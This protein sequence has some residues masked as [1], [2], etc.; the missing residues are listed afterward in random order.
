VTSTA[1]T[2]TAATSTAVTASLA[3][4][5][6][7]PVPAAAPQEVVHQA[8]RC[9]IDWLGVALAGSREP[10]T[11]IVR[12]TAEAMSPGA[13]AWVVGSRRRVGAP[14]AALVNGFAAH[15]LDYDDTFN[16]GRTTVHG[17]APVWPAVMAAASLR[18]LGGADAIAAF[19]AGFET[20]VRV[21]LAAGAGHYDAGWHVTGTVGHLGAAAAASRVLGLGTEQVV[22]AL[23]TAATQAAGMKAVYGSMGKALHPGK[24]AMDGLL[25]AALC[26][27]GFTSSDTAIEGHRGFLHLFAPDPE[28]ARALEG[29]GERWTVL[30]DGFKAYACGSLT[31]PS[32]DAV[33]ALRRAHGITPDRIA[34]IDLDV[35]DY[36]ITTTGL[37]EPRTGLEGKFSIFHCAAVAAVDGAARLAQFT[38]ERVNDGEVTAVRGRV[39]A[40][41]DPA[42]AKD[43]ATVT[44]T[45]T[46]G[47]AF[48]HTTA[49]NRGTPG[50]PVPDD[51]IEAKFLDLAAPVI[52]PAAKELAER[53]WHLD[54]EPDVDPIMALAA[55][56][57]S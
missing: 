48:S 27:R 56:E 5:V 25:S 30:D 46:D 57:R 2:S 41:H 26:A 14:F 31:H 53:C 1:V 18:R 54:D 32:I 20:E 15:V 17:S 9:L 38:D 51:E 40:R 50:N 52:G 23:G 49:H 11:E 55:G 47:T 7:G 45:L 29:L 13:D 16:P 19:L 44:I 24:A 28:P 43:A 33:I 6:S 39:H 8:K 10:G 35:H 42:K 4:F 12:E 37:A 34:R 21:A 3:A 36:V 22:A